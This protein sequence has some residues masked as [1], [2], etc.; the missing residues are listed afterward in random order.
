MRVHPLRLLLTAPA[1]LIRRVPPRHPVSRMRP[2]GPDTTTSVF[3]QA[4]TPLRVGCYG[5]RPEMDAIAPPP[6]ADPG[7]LNPQMSATA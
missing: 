3:R 1:R 7:L 2:G 5:R 4:A 6:P